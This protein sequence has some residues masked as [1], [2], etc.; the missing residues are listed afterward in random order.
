[1]LV[2]VI[3]KRSRCI[4]HEEVFL[5]DRR[6][7]LDAHDAARNEWKL[8][9]CWLSLRLQGHVWIAVGFGVFGAGAGAGA[10]AGGLSLDSG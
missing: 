4:T 10:G 5:N 7:A 2:I 9:H 1:M 6:A 3:A 8:L